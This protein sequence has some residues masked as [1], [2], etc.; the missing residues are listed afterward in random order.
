MVKGIHYFQPNAPKQHGIKLSCPTLFGNET[1]LERD[2][3]FPLF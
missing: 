1:T 2:V 3:W